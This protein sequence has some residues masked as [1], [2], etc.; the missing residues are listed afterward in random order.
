MQPKKTSTGKCGGKKTCQFKK[1]QKIATLNNQDF[2]L[3]ANETPVF[4]ES[5]ILTKSNYTSKI[6][7]CSTGPPFQWDCKTQSVLCVFII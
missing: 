4:L 5:S 7:I 1:T 2:N 3:N 6:N